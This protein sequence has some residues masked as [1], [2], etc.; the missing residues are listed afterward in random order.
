MTVDAADV[1]GTL[2]YCNLCHCPIHRQGT[3][4]WTCNGQHKDGRPRCT[5]RGCVPQRPLSQEN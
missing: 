5:M 2:R 4:D 3:Y 1:Q